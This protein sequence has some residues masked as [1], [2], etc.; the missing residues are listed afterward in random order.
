MIKYVKDSKK[1]SRKKRK[2]VY[3]FLIRSLYGLGLLI[4][5]L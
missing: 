3:D 5:M 4:M 2:G 1:L